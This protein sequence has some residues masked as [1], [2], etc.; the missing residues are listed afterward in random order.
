MPPTKTW[1]V[2]KAMSKYKP[3]KKAYNSAQVHNYVTS[4]LPTAELTSHYGG[5]A[6]Y[7]VPVRDVNL[8]ELF[9]RMETQKTLNGIKYWSISQASLEE[10]F[11]RIVR[12]DE[13]LA[14]T[15]TA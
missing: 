14:G 10:V 15:E 3:K 12:E 13:D 5:N 2:L 6:S 7:R 8:A 4:L 9:S 11:L 1:F